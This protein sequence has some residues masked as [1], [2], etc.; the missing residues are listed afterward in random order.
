MAAYN[1]CSMQDM[2][3]VKCVCVSKGEGVNERQ[4]ERL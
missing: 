3:Y 4:M 2:L 1:T